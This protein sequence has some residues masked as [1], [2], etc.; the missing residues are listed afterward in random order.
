MKLHFKTILFLSTIITLI[1]LKNPIF[2][3]DI[4]KSSVLSADT[5]TAEEVTVNVTIPAHTTLPLGRASKTHEVWLEM[6]ENATTTIDFGHFYLTV[7]GEEN[8]TSEFIR[9]EPIIQ[10]VIAA[11]KRGVTIRFLIEKKFLSSGV[12]KDLKKR[13]EGIKNIEFAL[14]NWKNLTNGILHS[15]YMVVD[16]KDSYIG[17]HNFDWKALTH[18]HET[19]LRVKNPEFADAV[20]YIFELD[21]SYAN[22]NKDAY[23][24]IKQNKPF[25]F[26]KSLYLVS[27]PAEYTPK[28]VKTGLKELKRLIKLAKKKI[29]IQLLHYSKKKRSGGGLFNEI[30]NALRAAAKRGVKVEMLISNWSMKKPNVNHLKDLSIVKNVSIKF[31]SIPQDPDPDNFINFARVMHSKVMRIDDAISWVGTSNWEHGYFYACRSLEV[32]TRDKT[33]AE[34]LDLL[35]YDLWNS[36]YAKL[37]DVNKKYKA[38]PRTKPKAEEDAE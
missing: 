27:S 36:S 18:I 16:R 4:Q 25:K 37:I 11:A 30:D 10:A 6:I 20:T 3:D 15:K 17:S 9:L 2:S 5:L 23:V 33:V 29:R 38:P 1:L 21:W 34:E 28:G 12:S 32:V 22:G 13:L 8:E 24:D 7:D 19:G 14:F 35:F 31:V 26:T